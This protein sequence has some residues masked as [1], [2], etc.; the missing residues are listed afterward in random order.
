MSRSIFLEIDGVQVT[1]NAECGHAPA[2]SAS[3]Q[4]CFPCVETHGLTCWNTWTHWLSKSS[5]SLGLQDTVSGD[6]WRRIL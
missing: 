6:A 5:K 4:F 1:S 2:N 3:V